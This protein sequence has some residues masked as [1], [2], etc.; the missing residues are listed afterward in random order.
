MQAIWKELD[1]GVNMKNDP[2]HVKNKMKSLHYLGSK[3]GAQKMDTKYASEPE[4][5]FPSLNN[6]ANQNEWG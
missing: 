6:V 5:G 4:L 1:Q 2:W 3:R